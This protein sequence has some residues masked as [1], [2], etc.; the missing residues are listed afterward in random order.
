MS[1]HAKYH[2]TRIH[3][4]SLPAGASFVISLTNPKMMSFIHI[5]GA[6]AFMSLAQTGK[7][8]E[9]PQGLTLGRDYDAFIVRP[10]AGTLEFCLQLAVPGVTAIPELDLEIETQVLEIPAEELDN[11]NYLWQAAFDYDKI[12]LPFFV[13]TRRSGDFFQPSGMGG[14]SKKLQ[15]Y[16]VD[17]KVPRL[18]R[19]TVP[20]LST[21]TDI[22][23]VVG[24]R[25][26]ERF[27]VG[28]ETIKILSIGIRIK[29]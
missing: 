29:R 14:K 28:P 12:R 26:D 20:I 10:K 27:L 9:L 3:A 22:V 17:E 2:V 24:M 18:K 15:D 19:D 1:V 6:L 13:R 4:A 16:F 11:K 25:T 21:E 8:M 23:W 5:E 7:Q